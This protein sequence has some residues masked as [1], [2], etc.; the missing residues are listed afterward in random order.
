MSFQARR[1]CLLGGICVAVFAL[2]YYT[3]QQP[4]TKPM[5]KQSQNKGETAVAQA[6]GKSAKK[7]L[8]RKRPPEKPFRNNGKRSD[9]FPN[10]RLVT[11]EN[12]TVRLYDDLVKDHTVIINFMYTRCTGI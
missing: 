7:T 1:N 3:N 5:A 9:Y 6:Y 10:I 8:N 4:V 2:V 11:H 12:K